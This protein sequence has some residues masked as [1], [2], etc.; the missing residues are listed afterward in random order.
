MFTE[1]HVLQ[2]QTNVTSM[3]MFHHSHTN[4]K[5]IMYITLVENITTYFK[6]KII[7][8]FNTYF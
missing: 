6:N 2:L 7:I 5:A 4:V 8:I 1:V 3:Q